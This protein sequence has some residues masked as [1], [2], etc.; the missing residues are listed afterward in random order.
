MRR[1]SQTGEKPAVFVAVFLVIFIFLY[2][3]HPQDT[4]NATSNANAHAIVHTAPYKTMLFPVSNSNEMNNNAS[5]NVLYEGVV[6]D[7][8]PFTF[9][10]IHGGSQSQ[11]ASHWLPHIQFFSGKGSLFAV[12]LLGHGNS[13]HLSKH[14]TIDEH[15]THLY[16]FIKSHILKS[17]DS[18]QLIIVARSFGGG[19]AVSLAKKLETDIKAMILVAPSVPKD[20]LKLSNPVKSKPILFFWDEGD[21]VVSFDK[22]KVLE[23][24]FKQSFLYKCKGTYS[25]KELW[26]SH[27]PENEFVKEFH[28]AI[29]D[30][31]NNLKTKID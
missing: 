6:T 15:A 23:K 27:T 3:Y 13:T 25:E 22:Y 12:D 21:N 10:L 8:K 2:T 9:V 17:T 1:D 7:N 14:P 11:N 4:T 26:K 24:T 16:T 30:F 20:L 19:V 29:D 18:K 28:E 31:L 5:M